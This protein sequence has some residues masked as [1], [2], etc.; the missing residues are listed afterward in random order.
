MR[1][2][3]PLEYVRSANKLN[4]LSISYTEHRTKKP[5]P[6]VM[7]NECHKLVRQSADQILRGVCCRNAEYPLS[8]T[9]PFSSCC[10]ACTPSRWMPSRKP[11][12]E[13]N[14]NFGY[15]ETP[16]PLTVP[17]SENDYT[18]PLLRGPHSF[19]V[20]VVTSSYSANSDPFGLG[21]ESEGECCVC[22]V[23]TEIVGSTGVLKILP[24]SLRMS[25]RSAGMHAAITVT[26]VSV[27]S[28][29]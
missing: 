11:M 7:N 4:K 5:S 21:L 19:P 27:M 24:V 23:L 13:G 14:R 29:M 16:S 22:G 17:M 20:L 2:I 26:V 25:R 3:V 10:L 6:R 9:N 18:I 28:Q 1:P 12:T 15:Q 8:M